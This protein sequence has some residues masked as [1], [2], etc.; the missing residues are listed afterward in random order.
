MDTLKPKECYR[1]LLAQKLI[2]E[3]AR[4]QMEG[5]YCES[6]A[7]AVTKVMEMI[8][9]DSMVACGG[10]ATL[11]ELGLR[12]ALKIADYNFLDPDDAKGGPAKEK[13]AHRAL[14]ADYY[15]MSSNA[16][17]ATGELV[18]LDGIGNRVAALA[19]GPKYVIVIAG[20]NKVVPNLEA[21][22]LRAKTYAAPHTLLLF[23]QAYS[24]FDEL[25]ND[26]E[27][28]WSQ[29]VITSK[30]VFKGRIKIVLVGESLGF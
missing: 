20:I 26:S 7:D 1:T 18:N 28:A 13:V 5:F 9:K 16:I 12:E 24:S 25:A 23:N 19:F 8:P 17:S 30:S 4:R 3:F 11:R 21:A 29:L 22:I 27:D 2:A 10:S 6:K 14:S 15:L